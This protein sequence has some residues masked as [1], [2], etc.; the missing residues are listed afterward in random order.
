MIKSIPVVNL[1][2]GRVQSLPSTTKTFDLPDDFDRDSPVAALDNHSN[3]HY[4]SIRGKESSRP[5]LSRPLSWRV[6]GEQCLVADN[7]YA[8]TAV[9][10]ASYTMCRV[11]P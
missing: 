5:V 10:R 2:T 3:A 1:S 11:E 4:R 8:P 9:K 7:D 6:R